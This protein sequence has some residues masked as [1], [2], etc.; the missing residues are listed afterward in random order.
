MSNVTNEAALIELL[1]KPPPTPHFFYFPF[2]CWQRASCQ[3]SNWLLAV[4][5]TVTVAVAVARCQMKNER[6][7]YRNWPVQSSHKASAAKNLSCL[8]APSPTLIHIHIYYII[9]LQD[10]QVMGFKGTN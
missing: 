7:N 4:T 8:S 3:G 10:V 6:D 2:F 9:Y 1:Q 5:V